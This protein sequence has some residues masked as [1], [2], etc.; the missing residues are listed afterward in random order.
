MVFPKEYEYYTTFV[1]VRNPY[2]RFLS[3]YNFYA[4]EG[5]G[6]WEFIRNPRNRFKKM[7]IAKL[8]AQRPIPGSLRVRIDYVLKVESL[9]EDFS[10]LPFV[11]RE[12][13]IPKY[14][15]NTNKRI[16]SYTPSI[17]AWVRNHYRKDFERFGYDPNDVPCAIPLYL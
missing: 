7:P 9:K 10:N 2:S 4:P 12:Y 6:V 17:A 3:I 8:L 15:L 16:T 14:N 11:M 1:T 13:D 5:M